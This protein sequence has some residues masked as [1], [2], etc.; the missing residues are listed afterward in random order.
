VNGGTAALVDSSSSSSSTLGLKVQ[1]ELSIYN[2]RQL[3][4]LSQAPNLPPEPPEGQGTRAFFTLT[5]NL[6]VP[7]SYVFS[8]LPD[9]TIESL[10][11]DFVSEAGGF[12][13]GTA[14]GQLFSIT[15]PP[16]S[17]KGEVWAGYRQTCCSGALSCSSVTE[18]L[19]RTCV[20]HLCMRA[21]CTA[22]TTSS[23][24][25]ASAWSGSAVLVAQLQGTASGLVQRTAMGKH[26]SIKR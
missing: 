20:L 4:A 13:L 9:A 11:A 10:L 6:L 3:A 24:A 14:T 2:G 17:G 26:S 1:Q 23:M 25:W 16:S 15:P 8:T 19:K 22:A 5:L 21:Q 18:R 7:S 12:R